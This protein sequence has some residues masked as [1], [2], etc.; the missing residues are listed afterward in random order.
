MARLKGF[1]LLAMLGAAALVPSVSLAGTQTDPEITDPSGDGKNAGR[2]IVKAWIGD[3][4][5]DD[6]IL[7]QTNVTVNIELA[8]A[9]SAEQ[10]TLFT[11]HERWTV[12][13]VPTA[14]LPA[15]MKAAYVSFVVGLG[16]S[17]STNAA[18]SARAGYTASAGTFGS[19]HT[20]EAGN[21]GATLTGKVLSVPL[22]LTA[23]L[24]GFTYGVDGFNQLFAN[25]V[26]VSKGPVCCNAAYPDTNV[27]LQTYD[28]APNTGFGRNW[29]SAPPAPLITTDFALALAS[30]DLELTSGTS[31][32]VVVNVT[33]PGAAELN[34]SLSAPNV[35]GGF[36]AVFEPENLTVPA[37][38]SAQAN[39]TVNTTRGAG[40]ETQIILVGIAADGVTRNATLSVRVVAPAPPANA[41]TT[42]SAEAASAPD[43]GQGIPGFAA[44]SMLLGLCAAGAALRRRR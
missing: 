42:E 38:G 28:R 41:T 7:D 37:N 5:D 43:E 4:L 20:S 29:I 39:L 27:I 6:G 33:N 32:V 2:D 17:G 23:R 12:W 22:S 35:S 36:D 44:A 40:N 8:G 3:A 16:T 1:L 24:K 21:T 34:I 19:L 11:V 25:V 31:G 14:G 10:T 9:P 18:V 26:L 15:G 13:F 30:T